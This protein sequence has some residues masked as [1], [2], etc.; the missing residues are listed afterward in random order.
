MLSVYGCICLLAAEM[1]VRT[2][3]ENY[4]KLF[5]FCRNYIIQELVAEDE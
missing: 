1:E 3:T 5:I 4:N 2:E